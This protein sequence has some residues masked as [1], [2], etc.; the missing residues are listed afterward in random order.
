M[1]LVGIICQKFVSFDEGSE[2]AAIETMKD[3]DQKVKQYLLILH[4]GLSM[5]EGYNIL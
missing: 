5:L 2:L 1:L 4:K 3:W